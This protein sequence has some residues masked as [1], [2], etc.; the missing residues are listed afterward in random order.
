ML[1]QQ[2]I[3]DSCFTYFFLLPL[4]FQEEKYNLVLKL[5]FFLYILRSW[6]QLY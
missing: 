2:S 6:K 5:E 4:Y 3:K 1:D